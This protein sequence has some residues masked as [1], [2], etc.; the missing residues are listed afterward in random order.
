MR[1]RSVRAGF[2]T[3]SSRWATTTMS[4][5]LTRA[6]STNCLESVR[7]TMSGTVSCGKR[8]PW[9]NGSTGSS[10]GSVCCCSW[11]CAGATSSAILGTPSRFVFALSAQVPL[12]EV[13]INGHLRCHA[14]K[15]SPRVRG[16]EMLLGN[17]DADGAGSLR[18]FRQANGEEPVPVGRAGGFGIHLLGQANGMAEG[19][20]SISIWR[21]RVMP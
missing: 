4:R 15:V 3:L 8:T 5:S 17:R 18:T 11:S 21:T 20:K 16:A 9:P 10:L 19:P 7:L 1:W 12:F 6:S 14:G 2:S 13:A